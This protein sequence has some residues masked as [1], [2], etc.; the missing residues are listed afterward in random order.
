MGLSR[1]KFTGE[2]K[3][4]GVRRLEL[5]ASV[6]EVARA[7]EVNPRELYRWRRELH[8]KAISMA[9]LFHAGEISGS[10]RSSQSQLRNGWTASGGQMG[11][12]QRSEIS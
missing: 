3:E 7:T 5:G 4:A 12:E 1:W 8:T 2:F 10:I 11:R 6:S 9:G